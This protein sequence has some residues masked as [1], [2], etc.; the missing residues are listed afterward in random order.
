M[1]VGISITP[2]MFAKVLGQLISPMTPSKNNN[3]PNT[4]KN[5]QNT[6]EIILNQQTWFA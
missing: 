3:V 4:N 6:F 2:T 5:K 1:Y